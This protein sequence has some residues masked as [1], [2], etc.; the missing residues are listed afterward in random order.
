MCSEKGNKEIY[1]LRAHP[2]C[3]HEM[4]LME[5]TMKILHFENDSKRINTLEEIEIAKVTTSNHMLN[6]MQ[7]NNPLYK[8]LHTLPDQTASRI[9]KC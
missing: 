7:N 5:E 9:D 2:D 1:F 3:G 4:R 6:I 8:I